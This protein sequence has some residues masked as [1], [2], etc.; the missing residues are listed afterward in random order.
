MENWLEYGLR[1]GTAIFAG[2]LI[3]FEREV[4][5]KAVGM[6]TNILICLGACL[7]MII[8]QE[9]TKTAG[10]RGDPSRI[11]AQV[12]TGIGFLGAGAIIR[13]QLHV[14]GLTTAATIWAL[15]A[16]GLVIGAGYYWLSV[17]G[18]LLIFLTLTLVPYVERAV[19]RRGGVYTVDLILD[20]SNTG[21]VLDA[22]RALQID[23]DGISIE[24]AGS[25]WKATLE[26]NVPGALQFE[27]LD[28]LARV[29]GVIRMAG[30]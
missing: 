29:E 15:A 11:A 10:A 7:L 19:R 3:G 6:R 18:M 4:R 17:L 12:V 13:S 24:R 28:A 8:S 9:I 16:L 21:G 5:G 30:R 23:P 25:L 20:R 1:L 22:L 26:L 27:A 14:S 2:G